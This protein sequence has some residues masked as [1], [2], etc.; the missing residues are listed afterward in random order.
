MEGMNQMLS[1]TE[2]QPNIN[3]KGFDD[4]DD[5]IEGTSGFIS[6][7]INLLKAVIGAGILAIPSAIGAMGWV[8][9]CLVLTL[10]AML[11]SLGLF[12]L[13]IVGHWHGR[14]S[15]FGLVAEKTFP[16]AALIFD[17]TVVLKCFGVA[18]AYLGNICALIPVIIQGMM[19][20]QGKLSKEDSPPA[21]LTDYHVAWVAVSLIILAPMASLRKIDSLKYSSFLGMFAIFYLV[22]LSAYTFGNAFVKG[23]LEPVR[24]VVSLNSKSISSFSIFVFAFNCH[25]NVFP[26]Q[27]EAL[28]NTPQWMTRV[29]LTV[30]I[31]TLSIYVSFGMF[32]YSTYANIADN[33][34]LT[35]PFGE[36]LF[37]V[38]RVLFVLLFVCSYPLQTF[39][40]R[41]ALER[42]IS[43]YSQSK[44]S[45]VV[46]WGTTAGIVLCSGAIAALDLGFGI[47]LKLIGSTAGPVICFFFPALLYIKETSKSKKGKPWIR[48]AAWSLLAFAVPSTLMSLFL[49]IKEIYEKYKK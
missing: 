18:T 36:P 29:V 19:I 6:C 49:T 22:A 37:I 41:A 11:S 26:I 21:W 47:A 15:T 20:Y 28:H 32:S 34:L 31:L 39:P 48:I 14:K 23:Q 7:T 16:S 2:R 35:W 30:M 9:G 25:Q 40:C 24:P 3:D 13:T 17:L 8:P 38:A 1:S 27:N 12:L 4:E 5:S 44:H 46:H 33:I 42:V 45:N 43:K 10:A